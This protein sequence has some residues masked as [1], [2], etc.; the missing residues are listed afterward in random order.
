MLA[1]GYSQV[2][3]LI[4]TEK[5][6]EHFTQVAYR[7]QVMTSKTQMVKSTMFPAKVQLESEE[8]L[9]DERRA[10]GLD[11]TF[12]TSRSYLEWKEPSPTSPLQQHSK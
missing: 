8:G 1:N 4:F 12:K 2:G 9:E 5:H 3:L 6:P 7:L 10:G 11:N